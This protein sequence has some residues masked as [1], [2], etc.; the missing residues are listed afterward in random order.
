MADLRT[1]T[2]DDLR[3]ALSSNTSSDEVVSALSSTTAATFT[4]PAEAADVITVACQLQNA[5]GDDVAQRTYVH[6]YLADDAAGDTPTTTGPDGGTIA[7]TDGSLVS[8]ALDGASKAIS[9][10]AW[11][12]TDGDLDVKMTE[13]GTA[14]WHLV[15]VLPNGKRAVSGAVTFAA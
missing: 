12:E 13:A 4:I 3:T 1:R 14:T 15:L 8:W 5:S 2:R 10:M 9:G 6:W 11:T 7:G